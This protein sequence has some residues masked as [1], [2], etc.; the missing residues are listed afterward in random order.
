MVSSAAFTISYIGPRLRKKAKPAATIPENG[1]FDHRTLEAFDGKNAPAYIAFRGKV[2][3]VS[4]LK[5]WRGGTHMKHNAGHDLSDAISKAP[6]GDEK[7]SDLK[8]VGAY[9]KDLKPRK[10]FAQKAFYF[11]AYMNLLIVFAVL[12]VIAYWRWGL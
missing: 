8:I 5:L 6:H 9:D 4:N 11:I 12:F 1:V 3:D 10:S 2:Y 7:L